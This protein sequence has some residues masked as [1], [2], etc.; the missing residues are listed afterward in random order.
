MVRSM[1]VQ[2]VQQYGN[3]CGVII[4]STIMKLLDIEKGDN[5]R[6]DISRR[7]IT[8]EKISEATDDKT[9]K[10]RKAKGRK[11]GK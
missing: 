6:M 11:R 2:R 1:L 7:G 8:L 3:S 5:L 9:K 4:P 10:G